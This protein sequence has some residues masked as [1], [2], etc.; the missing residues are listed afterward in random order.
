[1]GAAIALQL[2]ADPKLRGIIT[3]LVLDSPILDWVATIEANCARSGL[4]TWT[5]VLALPWLDFRPL[6]RL[7]GLANPIDLPS[8]DW[9][10]RANELTVPTL[11]LHGTVDMS[12]PFDLPTR[13]RALRPDLVDLE[14]FDADHTMSWN[15]DRQRWRAVV[16]SWLARSVRDLAASSD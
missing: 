3:G 12:S 16:F 1:M 6:A 7:I 2:A 8:L 13:L 5:G 4:P 9:I 15:S 11:I 10:G 14:F